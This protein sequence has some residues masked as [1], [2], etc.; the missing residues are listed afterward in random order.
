LEV[1]SN[2]E[3]PTGMVVFVGKEISKNEVF[4]KIVSSGK[5]IK[6]VEFLL[7]NIEKYLVGLSEYKIGDV[8]EIKPLGDSFELRKVIKS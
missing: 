6:D 8:L 4:S 3:Y 2:K 1:D 7:K 5:T